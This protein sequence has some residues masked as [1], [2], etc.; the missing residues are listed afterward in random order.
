MKILKELHIFTNGLTLFHIN[1][2]AYLKKYSIKKLYFK[3]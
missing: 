2:P 3:K 1:G